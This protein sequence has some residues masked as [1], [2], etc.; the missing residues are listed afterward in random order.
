MALSDMTKVSVTEAHELIFYWEASQDAVRGVS[1]VDWELRLAAG[2]RGRIDATFGSGWA[3]TIDGQAFS[4]ATSIAIAANSTKVLASGSVELQHDENG[5]KFFMYNFSQEF[6]MTYGG[7]YIQIVSGMGNGILTPIDPDAAPIVDRNSVYLGQPLT[8][9]PQGQLGA[10]FRLRYQLGSAEGIIGEALTGPV[11]W[12]VPETLGE[13]LPYTDRGTL[14]ILCDTFRD[15]ARLGRVRETPVTALVPEDAIPQVEEMTITDLGQDK[16]AGRY[17]QQ[18]SRLG[19]EARCVGSMGS[20]VVNTALFWDD[21]PYFGHIL[22]QY[23]EHTLR[24]TV[25]DSRG[26]VGSREVVLAVE[27]YASPHVWVTAHRCLEDGTADDTG[28]FAKI[29][30]EAGWAQ[31]EENRGLVTLMA[32]EVVE[33]WDF[34]GVHEVLVEADPD[35][36]MEI[37]V[38]AADLFASNSHQMVLSTGYCTLDLLYGGRGI[39]FGAAAQEPGFL[40]AMDA[41]F[42]G[43]VLLANGRDLMAWL[44]ELEEKLDPSSLYQVTFRNGELYIKKAPAVLLGTTLSLAAGDQ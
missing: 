1:R 26:R 27:E 19:V 20:K 11:T 14:R 28:G 13:Q 36:P 42:T 2:E 6:Y 4:G 24:L 31:V 15:G 35:V 44:T 43:K 21:T 29:T 3:V 10:T 9:T 5:Q 33:S 25:T 37:S 38:T 41:R 34:A 16:L 17:F 7:E 22:D 32:G 8:I 30:V 40:C 12:V 18:I 39:A 23:G